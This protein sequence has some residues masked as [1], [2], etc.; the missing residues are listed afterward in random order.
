MEHEEAMKIFQMM[1]GIYNKR[2]GGYS[3]KEA[4]TYA[5]SLMERVDVKKITQR[6]FHTQTASLETTNKQLAQSITSYLEGK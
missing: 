3:Q 2:G 1:I 4:L 5:L 6:I